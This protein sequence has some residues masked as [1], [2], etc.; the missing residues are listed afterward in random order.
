MRIFERVKKQMTVLSAI[1]LL[2]PLLHSCDVIQFGSPFQAP[3]SGPF[4][5]GDQTNKAVQPEL[6]HSSGYSSGNVFT[7]TVVGYDASVTY[8][9]TT[10]DGS[11][12]APASEAEGIDFPAGGIAIEKTQTVKV[13]AFEAELDP[14][15]VTEAA[16]NVT[17]IWVSQG[18]TGDGTKSDPFG[19]IQTGIDTASSGYEVRVSA[20]TYNEN[21][22]LTSNVSLKGGYAVG[23]GS[24]D[25][26]AVNL[27]L[28]A[29]TTQIQDPRTTGGA[30][31]DP[32]AAVLATGTGV[33]NAA[34]VE[35]FY[36]LGKGGAT[37]RAAALACKTGAAPTVRYNT[38]DA[39]TAAFAPR[40][41]FTSASSPI[42][43]NCTIY[44]ETGVR[45]VSGSSPTITFCDIP[46]VASGSKGIQIDSSTPTISNCSVAAGGGGA[47]TRGVTLSSSNAVLVNT[48]IDGGSGG[49][50]AYA[51][52]VGDSSPKIINCTVIA[53]STTTAYGIAVS[54]VTSAITVQN[55]IITC[56]GA[57]TLRGINTITAGA[58]P[59][60][61]DNN[62]FIGFAG[63]AVRY[64]SP[65]TDYDVATL[66]TQPEASGNV[67]V[68]LTFSA[69]MRITA[70]GAAVVGTAADVATGGLPVGGDIPSTDKDGTARPQG[71][72]V[73]MGAYEYASTAW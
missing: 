17:T 73:S 59:T 40:G 51:F 10:G 13:R 61:L 27:G 32:I 69:D 15:D 14:S 37:S 38:L 54:G 36:L 21:V 26:P 39:T 23:F 20:G 11:Q 22:T 12:A 29:N 8:R 19:S 9:Y 57:G 1:L 3:Y 41:L 31:D 16:L 58:I 71:G 28:G 46:G 65:V 56:T 60:A 72:G 48:T 49:T 2:L 66:N 47:N 4:E 25:D 63:I 53:D 42:V 55:S 50:T 5:A 44:G 7:L 6:S 43:S 34:V 30:L 68:A 45:I 70:D 35:G 18:G 62:N 24:R 52:Q 33:T 67:D 64:G